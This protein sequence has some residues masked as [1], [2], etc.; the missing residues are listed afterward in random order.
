MTILQ[1]NSPREHRVKIAWGLERV[2]ITLLSEILSLSAPVV[3]TV[4]NVELK[5][6]SLNIYNKK[7][8][9]ID[10]IEPTVTNCFYCV[11]PL[12]SI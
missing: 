12:C 7:K 11:Q 9:H 6:V 8:E 2:F 1:V 4:N 5:S 3:D 10:R